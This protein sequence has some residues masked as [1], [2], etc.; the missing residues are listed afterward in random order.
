MPA[1]NHNGNTIRGVLFD[2]DGTLRHSRP[3][4]NDVIWDLIAGLGRPASSETRR[5]SARWAHYYWAQSQELKAD[6]DAF[7]GS[8]EDFW[9][10]YIRR[11][12]I[13]AGCSQD[14]TAD[15]AGDVHRH[16]RDHYQPEDWVA[17]DTTATLEQLAS[18]G[19]RMGVLSN[20]REPC[21]DQLRELGLI[22]Y[23]N[24]A[25]VAGQVTSWKPEPEIFYHALDRLG[26][27][28][29]ETVYV[30]D[31]YYADVIGAD[32]AGLH[33]ILIDPDGIFPEAACPVIHE[34]GELTQLL[35]KNGASSNGSAG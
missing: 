11:N 29:Q 7:S 10:N 27:R 1:P 5:R 26:T 17:P 6:L 23:F 8:E 4:A 35:T 34:I 25:L 14:A 30:G 18:N 19:L 13:G 21:D 20:R 33:P 9:F 15:L 2:L 16:M 28:P 22:R 32:Q 24:F 3:A 12:L 31:N